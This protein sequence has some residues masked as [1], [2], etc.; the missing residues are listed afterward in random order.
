MAAQ[1]TGVTSQRVR[2]AAVG[3]REELAITSRCAE[4]ASIARASIT[5]AR[6]SSSPAR[7]LARRARRASRCAPTGALPP[8]LTRRPAAARRSTRL[9]TIMATALCVQPAALW[10]LSAGRRCHAVQSVGARDVMAQDRR[11]CM[12]ASEA[13]RRRLRRGPTRW[14]TAPKRLMA[15]SR[16]A[17]TCAVPRRHT[18]AG[19]QPAVIDAAPCRCWSCT[20]TRAGRAA[21]ARRTASCRR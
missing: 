2:V 12:R 10:A 11:A 17:G 21:A 18:H 19:E 8:P 5:R 20:T 1:M 14:C 6:R 3:W 15:L 16:C 13:C 4:G 7:S 9:V